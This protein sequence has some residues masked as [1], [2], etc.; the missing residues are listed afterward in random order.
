MS[1][2]EH[3]DFATPVQVQKHIERILPD[4][5]TRVRCLSIFADSMERLHE[6]DPARWG[7]YCEN[8]H[9]RLRGGGLIVLTVESGR[10]WLALDQAAIDRLDS[11]AT[12]LGAPGIELDPGRWQHYKRPRT[13]NVFYA[14]SGQT[15]HVWSLIRDLHF[16]L[17]DRVARHAFRP[18]SQDKHQPAVSV[19]LGALLRRSLPEPIHIKRDGEADKHV[20]FTHSGVLPLVA[21]LILQAAK[22]HPG[23]W[24]TH[25]TLVDRFLSDEDGAALLARARAKSAFSDDRSA[26]SNM[27]AWFSETI[28]VGRS[29]WA[30]LFER[31]QVDGAWAYRPAAA[32]TFA[33]DPDLDVSALEGEPRMFLHLRRERNAALVRAKRAAVR[34]AASQLQCEACGF[35]AQETYPDR[36]SGDLCEVH[37]RRPLGELSGAAETRLDDL[38]ILCPNCHRAIHQTRPMMRVEDLRE[39]FRRGRV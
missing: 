15:A 11:T 25:K 39:W 37:H 26:A 38:A 29:E 5:E 20:S 27:V 12:L 22:E 18:D 21:R 8:D 1:D 31:K 32:V 34:N 36:L 28:S 7:T 30:E 17:L 10:L 24:V 3:A 23:D 4:E 19:Y 13:T 9:L 6:Q 14:P 33:T 2:D 16:A 35:V